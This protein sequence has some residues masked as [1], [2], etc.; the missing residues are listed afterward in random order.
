MYRERISSL[1]VLERHEAVSWYGV[2]SPRRPLVMRMEAC[3]EECLK[4]DFA[5]RWRQFCLYLSAVL[6]HIFLQ[7]SHTG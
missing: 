4:V 2:M 5:A 6:P 7:S 3:P 1:Q